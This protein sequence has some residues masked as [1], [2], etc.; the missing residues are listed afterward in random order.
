MALPDDPNFKHDAPEALLALH[1]LDLRAQYEEK[2]RVL[3]QIQ[4]HIERY[5]NQEYRGM[6]SESKGL[7]EQQLTDLKRAHDYVSAIV[8]ASLSQVRLL[9]E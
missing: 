2:L 4:R 6:K 1:V 7:M 3:T 5:R 9:P 8:S